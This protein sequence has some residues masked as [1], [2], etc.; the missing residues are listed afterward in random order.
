MIFLHLICNKPV[1]VSS[2][3]EMETETL[4]GVESE[5]CD[6]DDEGEVSFYFDT[7]CIYN[8]SA[9]ISLNAHLSTFSLF[10][11]FLGF[12]LFSTSVPG[13]TAVEPPAPVRRRPVPSSRFVIFCF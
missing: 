12:R 7:C 3:T 11:P 13:E 9:I 10:F 8:H 1:T 2:I 6:D 4:P 5:K